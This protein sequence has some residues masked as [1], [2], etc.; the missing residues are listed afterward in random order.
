M[1]SSPQRG[2]IA[3][4]HTRSTKLLVLPALL[5]LL[6]AEPA[7]AQ[8]PPPERL[9]AAPLEWLLAERER[10]GLTPAQVERLR[11]AH[12]ALS[13]RNDPLLDRMVMLRAEWQRERQAM[14]RAGLRDETP[15]L[16]RIR[17]RTEPVLDRIQRNNQAAMQRVNE[18]L[19]PPQRQRLRLL[20]QQQRTVAPQRPGG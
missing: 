5:V 15:R 1:L 3:M 4:H 20:L 8:F 13:R 11:E 12:Q 9:G 6:T 18:L 16:R 14:Q 2:G 7:T 19:T 10:V 17:A